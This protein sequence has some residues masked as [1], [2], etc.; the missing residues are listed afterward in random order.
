MKLDIFR[1]ALLVNTNAFEASYHLKVPA[2]VDEAPSVTVPLPH[3]AALIAV[4]EDDTTYAV[5]L[6]RG[7]VHVP[8]ENST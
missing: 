8:F 7:L 4:S 3:L 6:A 2:T 5:T 1:P